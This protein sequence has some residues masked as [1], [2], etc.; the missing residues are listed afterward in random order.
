MRRIVIK[1]GGGKVHVWLFQ[2]SFTITQKRNTVIVISHIDILYAER[3]KKDTHGV[4]V[5]VST[6]R[7]IVDLVTSKNKLNK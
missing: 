2:L 1:L 4:N 5:C 3:N 6:N 7:W